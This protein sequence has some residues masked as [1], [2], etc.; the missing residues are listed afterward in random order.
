MT[1][2]GGVLPPTP[3]SRRT[4]H[5]DSISPLLRSVHAVFEAVYQG[6]PGGFDDV[7]GDADG[8]PH[9][10]AVGGVYEDAGRGGGGAV[11]VQD[12]DLVVG[13]V[14]LLEL[15]IVR[16]YGLSQGAVQ[17]VD[18]TVALGGGDH[19]VPVHGE[20]Y[21]RLRRGLPAGALFG[22]DPERLQ[23][24]ERP[25]FALRPPDEQGQRRVR[26]LVV[27]PLV[28]ALLD[29]PEYLRRVPGL[30]PELLGLGPDGVLAR[31]L[32]NGSAAHVPHGL[33]RDVLVGRRIFGDAVDVQ[34]ALVGE[35]AASDVWPVRVW[36]QVHELG[37][38]VRG[39]RQ[40]PQ[41]LVF[42]HFE[43][44]LELQI[45]DGRDEVAVAAPFAYAVD[46]PLHVRRPGLHRRQGIAHP[47]PRIV[48]GVY[49]DLDFGKLAHRS[50]HDRLQLGREGA[51]VGVAE[52]QGRSSRL[53]RG[54]QHR[55]RICRVVA[56]AVEV[57]FGVE[58]D[59]LAG[60]G[61]VRYRIAH[62][63]EVLLRRCSQDLLDVKLP[64]LG[65]DAGDGR[66]E[67][68]EERDGGVVPG[69]SARPP[70][71]REGDEPRVRE[72][73]G[74][75]AFEELQVFGVGCREARFDVVDAQRVQLVGYA[76]LVFGG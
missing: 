10:L 35:G 63:L 66:G 45:G 31:E 61:Q 74:V 68:G 8:A 25:I 39:F 57:V 11:L 73:R 30:Q 75:E 22:D 29:G 36:R 70:C 17:G 21:G 49:A 76:G 60:T 27:V 1:V 62:G 24:E 72:R 64:A 52:D 33:R 28:L 34:P 38:V 67:G 32:A 42:H 44:H 16:P 69:P 9:P 55:Q 14:D 47:A 15:G 53:R 46:R 13:Q 23:L 19:P 65:D 71:P 58:D 54:P 51:A 5:P 41:L 26:G 50:R 3:Y 18:G 43:V 7:F 59:F 48:V 20:F 4:L 6:L 56:E 40:A 2:R 12:A 37:N